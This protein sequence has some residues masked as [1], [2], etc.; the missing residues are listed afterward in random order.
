MKPE[1]FKLVRC[2]FS[3]IQFILNEILS[4]DISVYAQQSTI[5]R[6]TC[7]EW[8]F[9]KPDYVKLLFHIDPKTKQTQLAGYISYLPL[10]KE[11]VKKLC[12]EEIRED[13]IK[14][15]DIVPL[16]EGKDNTLW[17][18]SVVVAPKY[19]HSHAFK[20]LYESAFNDLIEYAKK[21]IFVDRVYADVVSHI[22]A[23]T[24][25]K[26]QMKPVK[27]YS[28]IHYIQLNPVV[29]MTL[30]EKDKELKR[31]YLEKTES[32]HFDFDRKVKKWKQ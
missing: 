7:A 19:Q 21:G 14:P 1:N 27:E 32:L 28:S 9:K 5:S 3:H 26:I 23:I 4:L 18:C 10:S 15:D 22:T 20:M 29:F 24:A 25:K 13:G 6:E 2:N 17:V 31:Y 11:C 12:D 8:I 30:A 16:K